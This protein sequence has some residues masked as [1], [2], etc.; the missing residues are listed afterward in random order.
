MLSVCRI[1]S[2]VRLAVACA[3]A[4]VG[5]TLFVMRKDPSDHYSA[6]GIDRRA[7]KEDIRAAYKQA[8]LRFHPDKCASKRGVWHQ[9]LGGAERCARRFH[10]A[11]AAEEALSDDVTRIE[12]D[13]ELARRDADQKSARQRW[14]TRHHDGGGGLLSWF[15]PGLLVKWV[16]IACALLVCWT[17]AV[18]PILRG[19][20]RVVEPK[21]VAA[22]RS[23]ARMA[24]VRRAQDALV[25]ARHQEE[26]LSAARR[27]PDPAPA[28]AGRPPAP[29][30]APAPPPQPRRRR[31]APSPPQPGRLLG[32]RPSARVAA[33]AAARVAA[34]RPASIAAAESPADEARRVTDETNGAYARS[35][36]VDQVK[37]ARRDA[38]EA[39]AAAEAAH[40][41]L[42]NDRRERAAKLIASIEEASGPTAKRV[43]VRLP[44]GPPLTRAFD[45]SD[46][47]SLVRAFV[48]AS[49]KAPENFALVDFG[50]AP[51][52]TLDDDA[53][54]LSSLS[55][56]NVTLHVMDLDA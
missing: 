26:A 51:M 55:L 56:G 24:A 8:A 53:A 39:A 25:A 54:A 7:S 22:D 14:A 42:L 44:E 1:M 12:Y 3:V 23:A 11:S 40:E 19:A 46:P 2:A 29:D 34:G 35:L 17:Y 49:G 27:R 52:R 5:A 9:L 47:I 32:W 20:K 43:R 10:A 30:A 48:D 28:S 15:R 50:A 33:A 37:A 6:L 31:S 45:A 41:Q 16:F 13:V 38:E 4:S 21:N 36:A 18:A